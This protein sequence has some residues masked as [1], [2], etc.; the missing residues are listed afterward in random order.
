L[1]DTC[2][3]IGTGTTLTLMNSDKFLMDGVIEARSLTLQG[4]AHGV[5]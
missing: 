5:N 1:L 2:R 3:K 4:V